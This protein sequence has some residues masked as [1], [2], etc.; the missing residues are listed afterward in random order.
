MS[1]ARNLLDLRHAAFQPAEDLHWAGDDERMTAAID[2]LIKSGIPVSRTSAI[3][4]KIGSLSFYPATG[5]LNFDNQRRLLEI[6]LEG[7]KTVLE[8]STGRTLPEID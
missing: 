5:T 3:Q 6:G 8:R 4:L 1:K 7:L 2:W